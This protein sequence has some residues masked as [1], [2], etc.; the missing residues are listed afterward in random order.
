MDQQET[1]GK[2]SSEL[3]TAERE[4]P[5]WISG[6]HEREQLDEISGAH[7]NSDAESIGPQTP[8]TTGQILGRKL[9]NELARQRMTVGRA[10]R[11]ARITYLGLKALL[12]GNIVSPK[13]DTL[14]AICGVVGISLADLVGDL[15]EL[16]A[17]PD[18]EIGLPGRTLI[19]EK[20]AR[21]ILARKEIGAS[22]SDTAE[23]M[24]LS[25]ALV[26]RVF[27]GKTRKNV[28]V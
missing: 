2:Q 13:I 1:T 23:S 11:R 24:G 12:D 6:A 10:A 20:I 14:R 4:D 16:Q 8:E 28:G 3:E 19:N 27:H 26:Y 5:D 17:V 15:D 25:Y 21:A 22:V 7:G 18:E 9:K